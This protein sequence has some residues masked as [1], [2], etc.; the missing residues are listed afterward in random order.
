MLLLS[1]PCQIPKHQSENPSR[2]PG[3]TLVLSG[4][5]DIVSGER[6]VAAWYGHYGE[7]FRT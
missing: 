7:G 4:S 2:H 6:D 3:N 1:D 5:E